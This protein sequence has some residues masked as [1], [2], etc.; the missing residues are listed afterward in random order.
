MAGGMSLYHSF[1]AMS[2]SSKANGS[3]RTGDI[4]DK[5]RGSNGSSSLGREIMITAHWLDRITVVSKDRVP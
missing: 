2:P 4:D 3:F 1:P 5:A